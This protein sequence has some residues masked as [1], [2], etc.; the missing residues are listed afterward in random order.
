M[1]WNTDLP[2]KDG[3]Y[4]VKTKTIHPILKNEHVMYATIRTSENG[5]RAWSF[6]NQ[7]FLAYLQEYG[8][9]EVEL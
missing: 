6:T 5:K 2:E 4:I 9:T 8:N 7:T 1:N 3:K